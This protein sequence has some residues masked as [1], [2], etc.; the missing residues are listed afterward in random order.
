VSVGVV[1]VAVVVFV[2]VV[3]GGVV[4]VFVGVGV[5]AAAVVAVGGGG[6]AAAAGVVAVA[7]AVDGLEVA[8]ELVA[9]LWEGVMVGKNSNRQGLYSKYLN[10]LLL[11]MSPMRY[12]FPIQ[13]RTS[14]HP[15]HP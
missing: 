13:D 12:H 7:V 1:A 4:V 3:G 6:V 11:T 10:F 8:V 5:V 14:R 15:T 2:V 9:L